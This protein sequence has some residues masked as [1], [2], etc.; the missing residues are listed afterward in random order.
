MIV[1]CDLGRFD[2]DVMLGVY[3][4]IEMFDIIDMVDVDVFCVCVG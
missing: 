1:L 3:V 2:V 4:W